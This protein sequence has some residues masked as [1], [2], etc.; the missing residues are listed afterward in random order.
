LEQYASHVTSRLSTTSYALL[1]LLVFDQETA[2]G[3]MTGYEVKQRAD[4]TLRFYWVSPAMSQIY[5]ELER[6]DRHGYVASTEV[7]DGKRTT[8]RFAITAAGR[9]ALEKWLRTPPDEFP[10]LKHPI[11]LRLMLGSLMD[12]DDVRA[13]LDHYL[14]QLDHRRGELEAVREMLAD[15]HEVRFPARVADWGL[16]YYDAEG[17]IVDRLR[18]DLG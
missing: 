18:K 5:T 2:D 4:N 9:K 11:A 7:E 16:A 6:L 14:E 17:E 3:G 10:V 1:G 8:R 13:M 15:R 12:P